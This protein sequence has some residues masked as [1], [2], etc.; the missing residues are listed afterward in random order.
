M[1]AKHSIEAKVVIARGYICLQFCTCRIGGQLGHWA[2]TDA[3]SEGLRKRQDREENTGCE[4]QGPEGVQWRY[5]QSNNA[6]KDGRGSHMR[7]GLRR[8]SL[9]SKPQW[10]KIATP[11]FSQPA[12]LCIARY[13]L[14]SE[15]TGPHQVALRICLWFAGELGCSFYSDR[16]LFGQ[17]SAAGSVR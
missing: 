6:N 13:C 5:P 2:H 12:A 9:H 17:S 7:K 1:S 10:L 4:A 11:S 3:T 15:S 8:H 14:G 16:C